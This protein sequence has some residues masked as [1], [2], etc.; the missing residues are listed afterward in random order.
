MT[1]KIIK[2][3]FV[4]KTIF[5]INQYASTPKT[6]MGGRHYYLAKELAKQGHK[7]YLVA[8]SYTHML[9]N[10]PKVNA[11]FKTESVDGFVFVWVRMPGYASAHDKKR[12]LN[13]IGFAWKL[14]KLPTVIKEKPDVVLVSSPSIFSF[15]GGQRL[16]KK[17]KAKLVFEVRDIWPL[18]LVE[19]G[20]YSVSHPFIRLLQWIE[21]KAYRESDAVIS[22]LPNAV[23]HMVEHGMKREKFSWIPNGLDIDEV[24]QAQ[25]L[26]GHTFSQLPKDKFIVGFAGTLGAAK[27]LNNFIDAASLLKDETRL[28]WVLVG[29][30]KEKQK[31]QAQCTKLG[32]VNVHFIS[33]IPKAQMQSLL[34]LFDVCYLGWSNKPI[35]RFGVAANKI[36]EYLYSGKPIIHGFSGNEDAVCKAKAGIS[37]PAENPQAIADAVLKLKSMSQEERAQ[38]GRNG[39]D[40]A[41]KN[42]DYAK[43]AEKLA[44]VLLDD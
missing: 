14:L 20:G 35:Y 18:T 32:L 6:G 34:T 24:S 44:K 28:A 39:Y 31:L 25:P 15:L 16:A 8:A 13:W 10:L 23:E 22:N 43:L 38:L 33:P 9:R 26:S 36:P 11:E 4:S 19:L 3:S 29:G 17:L 40:Y 41:L 37:I 12:V 7:V 21:N 27:V 5:I 42:H 30:G 2:G 1:E